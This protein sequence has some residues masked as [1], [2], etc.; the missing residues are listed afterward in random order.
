MR[1]EE[2]I[3]AHDLQPFDALVKQIGHGDMESANNCLER[4][5]QYVQLVDMYLNAT[6]RGDTGG[7]RINGR[8]VARAR[9]RY[10]AG[11]TAVELGSSR[12]F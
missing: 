5:F 2:E 9:L 8:D 11:G 3:V 12:F 4:D 6:V 7:F 1:I 10:C